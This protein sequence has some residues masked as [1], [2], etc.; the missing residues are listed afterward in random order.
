MR[1]HKHDEPHIL[2]AVFTV[3]MIFGITIALSIVVYAMTHIQ[4]VPDNPDNDE[5]IEGTKSEACVEI[6]IFESEDIVTEEIF[7]DTE[8]EETITIEVEEK[9]PN[10]LPVEETTQAY[11]E[12]TYTEEITEEVVEIETGVSE[13][14]FDYKYTNIEAIYIAKTI[15]VEAP[16]CAKMEQAAVAWCILNRVD[17]GRFGNGIIDVITR[18]YQ[19]GYRVYTPLRDDLYDLAVDVLERWNLEKQGVEDVGRILPKKYLFFWGDGYHNHFRINETDH[20]Y[21]DWSL[22]NPYEG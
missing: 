8:I 2:N 19:F 20:W 1:R 4:V 21:W 17:N 16:Y 14:E 3:I 18:P 11:I 5:I 12:E 13:I 7:T 6:P 15:G 22:P 10:I 9:T